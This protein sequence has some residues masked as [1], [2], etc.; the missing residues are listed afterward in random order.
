MIAVIGLGYVGLP[1]ADELGKHF[2]VLGYDN[3]REKVK[4]LQGETNSN[5][6]RYSY[7]RN[8]LKNPEISMYIIC[9]PT[10]IDKYNN[11]DLSCLT[12]ASHAVGVARMNNP[13]AIVVYES[14][15]YPGCTEEWCK[16][17]LEKYCNKP[18][19]S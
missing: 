14:T 7:F 11:P 8:D 4:V 17:I 1:L 3:D 15:V 5:L 12:E 10:P 16:P 18:L 13:D 2:G 9:V 6:I 19:R